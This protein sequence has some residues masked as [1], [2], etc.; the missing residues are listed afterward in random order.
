M[1][2]LIYRKCEGKSTG[3]ERGDVLFYVFTYCISHYILVMANSVFS[4]DVTAAML[5]G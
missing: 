2:E 5:V 3:S 4:C 1:R